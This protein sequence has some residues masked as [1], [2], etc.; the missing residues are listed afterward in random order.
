M[1]SLMTPQWVLGYESLN[2]CRD[3]IH[4]KSSFIGKFMAREDL[5]V[6][7]IQDFVESKQQEIQQAEDIANQL[8]SNAYALAKEAASI[9]FDALSAIEAQADEKD[10]QVAINL[11]NLHIDTNTPNHEENNENNQFHQ[12]GNSEENLKKKKV[13][14]DVI[15]SMLGETVFL[16]QRSTRLMRQYVEAKLYRDKMVS[17]ILK[18]K[19]TI[20]HLKQMEQKLLA[21]E[22]DAKA[23]GQ[24]QKAIEFRKEATE[25]RTELRALVKSDFSFLT[26]WFDSRFA[27]SN[28]SH[29]GTEATAMITYYA[30]FGPK[31]SMTQTIIKAFHSLHYASSQYDKIIDAIKKGDYEAAE[32]FIA[33]TLQLS[34]MQALSDTT[35]LVDRMEASLLTK[36]SGVA[37]EGAKIIAEIRGAASQLRNLLDNVLQVLQIE[38]IV[39]YQEGME[40][41]IE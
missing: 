22:E 6:D 37:K 28:R 27:V 8:R 4:Q 32:T 7:Q 41:G 18:R 9:H 2:E 35:K 19:E 23:R 15:T 5:Y 17:A 20:R 16:Q 1:S 34:T 29:V 38:S 14:E 33:M 40:E 36:K 10:S 13:S 11:A 31:G 26:F 3:L 24:L 21:A 25:K 12:E 39:E 30:E